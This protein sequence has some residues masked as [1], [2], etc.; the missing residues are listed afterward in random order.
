MSFSMFDKWRLYTE[1]LVS[2]DDYIDFGFYYLMSASLQR[3]VWIGPPHSP[4]Y[5]NLYIILVGDPAVG[6][7]LVVKQISKLLN[8]HKMPTSQELKSLQTPNMTPES[9]SLLESIATEDYNTAQAAEGITDKGIKKD[10][11]RPLLIPVAANATT[12]EALVKA[13]AQSIRRKNVIMFNEKTG[14]DELK[15]YTHSSLCFVLEEIS[16]LFRKKSEDVVNLLLEAYDCGDYKK[17]TKTQGVDRVKSC[18][19]NLF[20]G[21]TP[22]FMQE[23]FDDRLLTEGFSSRTIFVYAPCNRKTAVWMPDLTDAQNQAY[24]DIQDHIKKLTN[25]YGRI[26]VDKQTEQWFEDWWKF[27]QTHRANTSR[28]LVSYYGRKQVHVL[29][30]AM[31]HHF[32]HSFDMELKKESLQWAIDRLDVIER[33]MH[34]VLGFEST[35]PQAIPAKKILAFIRNNGAMT[36]KELLTEFWDSLPSPLTDMDEILEHLSS[37]Q[38]LVKIPITDKLTNTTRDTFDIVRAI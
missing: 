28:H 35:N 26:S 24:L 27:A 1:G 32:S 10:F 15:P 21:T 6:K 38:K 11:D 14:R 30:L 7:G 19:L 5:P 2:P 20:G 25:L 18:C 37:T 17:D 9:K 22:G 33:K 29:K 23:T 3:R 13:L 12:Y 8:Y 4:L 16:S 36:R 31:A 34:H